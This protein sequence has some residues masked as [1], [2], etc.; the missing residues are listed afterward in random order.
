MCSCNTASKSTL[1]LIRG[2]AARGV[3]EEFSQRPLSRPLRLYRDGTETILQI[4][5]HDTIPRVHSLRGPIDVPNGLAREVASMTTSRRLIVICA[6]TLALITFPRGLWW[7]R[8][9]LSVAS[10]CREGH[11]FLRRPVYQLL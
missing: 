10:Q 1:S 4:Y 2:V 3:G 5:A 9:A 7:W 6:L 8:R 11:N